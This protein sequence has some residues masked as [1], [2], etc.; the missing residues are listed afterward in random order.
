VSRE[1]VELARANVLGLIETAT[2]LADIQAAE[3]AAFGRQAAMSDV[4]RGLA[5]AAP[6]QKAAI[7]R[8][9]NEVRVEI[10]AALAE[11]RAELEAVEEQA[12]ALRDRIDVTLPGR[13]RPPG[14]PHPTTMVMNRIVDV[15]IGMG[16][17]VAEGPEVETVY[18]NFEALNFPPD[19]PAH[20]MH[21][22]LY[23]AGAPTLLRTHTSPVQIRTM[24]RQPP[25][26]YV[27]IPGRC[28]RRD[29]FDA[30]HSPV[31]HQIEGLAVDRNISLADLKGTLLEFARAIFGPDQEIRMRPSYFPFTEPSAE[32]DATC[33]SCGGRGCGACGRS[34]WMEL[35]GCGMVH[36]QVLRN[37]GYDPKVWS[38]FAFG[39][40][41][42]R[43]A[44]RA[45]D[46]PDIRM[47]FEN[48]LRFLERFAG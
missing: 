17:K 6:D 12:A 41:P 48:D 36:P 33:V 38:G 13:R 39:M 19:H 35:L 34:G 24:E 25:P 18:Y 1:I 21:D 31:F 16:Y 5:S 4:K 27:V 45:W 11:R 43:I 46:I 28:Y 8:L 22:T 26:V 7:G 44:M 3:V 32:V 37:A 40:G 9:L 29:P 23:I 42:D 10:E 2:S 47:L 30:T 20:T 15:F 14:R